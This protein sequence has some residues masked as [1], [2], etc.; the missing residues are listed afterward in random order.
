MSMSQKRRLLSK[1][2]DAKKRLNSLVSGAPYYKATDPISKRRKNLT[3]NFFLSQI[4]A[5]QKFVLNIRK[6]YPKKQ[7]TVLQDLAWLDSVTKK[8]IMMLSKYSK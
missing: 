8:A 1:A 5:G 3:K 7:E 4:G 6:R 2:I